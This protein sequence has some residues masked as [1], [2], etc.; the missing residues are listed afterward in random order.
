MGGQYQYKNET[1]SGVSRISERECSARIL[2]LRMR[3]LVRRLAESRRTREPS[4]PC[5]ITLEATPTHDLG[6]RGQ[7]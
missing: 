4:C 7:Q 6:R 1:C 5:V 3:N 2:I